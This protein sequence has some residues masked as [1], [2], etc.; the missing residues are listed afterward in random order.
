MPLNAVIIAIIKGKEQ[1]F[2]EEF[3]G[4]QMF[5]KKGKNAPRGFTTRRSRQKRARRSRFGLELRSSDEPE[6]GR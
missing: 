3:R 2:F 5:L 6:R 1:M 4:V